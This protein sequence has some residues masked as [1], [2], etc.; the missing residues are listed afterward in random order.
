MA[1]NAFW[2]TTRIYSRTDI[3]LFPPVDNVNFYSDINDNTICG[4]EKLA[5]NRQ[6]DFLI[7]FPK[8]IK[9]KFRYM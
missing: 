9:R 4:T 6:N 5:R 3:D 8:P 1:G 7:G 2:C